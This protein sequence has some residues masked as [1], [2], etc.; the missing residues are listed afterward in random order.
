MGG[1]GAPISTAIQTHLQEELPARADSLGEF[2]LTLVTAPGGYGKTT[3]VKRWR[4]LLDA[5][6]RAMAWLALTELHADPTLFL[7]DL[8]DALRGVLPASEPDRP[9]FGESIER[10]LPQR[11]GLEASRIARLLT[12][13]LRALTDRPLLCLDAFEHLPRESVSFGI[14]DALLRSDPCPLH[15]VVTT[16]GSR[17]DAATLLLAEGEAQEV[18]AEEL[19]LRTA[20]VSAVLRDAGVEPEE[21]LVAGLLARTQGWAMAARLAARALAELPSARRLAFV[22]EIGTQRDLFQYIGSELLGRTSPEIVRLLEASAVLGVA[23]AEALTGTAGLGDGGRAVEEAL[24]AGLLSGDG[25]ALAMHDLWAEWLR[26]RL[27]GRGDGEDWKATQERAGDALCSAGHAERALAHFV[28]ALPSPRVEPRVV[29][30]LSEQGDAWVSQGH[31][32]AVERALAALPVRLRDQVP[33][34]IAL[35]GLLL[36]GSD[37]DEAI[38]HLKSAAEAYGQTGNTRAEFMCL[39]ELG[40][41][42]ANE[43]RLEETLAI[44][45]RALSLRRLVTEPT[46]RGFVVLALGAGAMLAGR[47]RLALRLTDAAATYDHH[48]RERGGIGIIQTSILFQQGAWNDAYGRIEGL[49]ARPEQRQHGLSYHALQVVRAGIDSAR[50]ADPDG[51]RARLEEATEV[52]ADAHQSLNQQRAEHALAD[53]LQRQH[54]DEAA[55]RHLERAAALARRIELWEA[56]AAALGSLARL[57]QRSGD[58]D[59]ARDAALQVLERLDR[60]EAWSTRW[61]AFFSAPGIALACCVAADLGDAQRALAFLGRHRRRLE[62][63]ELPLCQHAVLTCAARVASRAGDVAGARK[64]LRGAWQAAE[65]AGLVH[66]S[67][68]LDGELLA[69]SCTEARVQGVSGKSLA[70]CLERLGADRPPALRLRSFGGL[71]L[72]REGRRVPDRAWRGAT[73]RR[74]LM[75]LLAAEGRALTRERIEADLW[76]ELP[77]DR[78]RNNLRVAI[79]RLRD[80]LEPRRRRGN[81]VPLLDVA[82]ERV[83]LTPDAIAAWD[84]SGW[85]G[86]LE[87]IRSATDAGDEGGAIDAARAASASFEA[88]FLPESYDDWVLEL[89]RSLETQLV[90]QGLSLARAWLERGG[91]AAAVALARLVLARVPDEE[92]AWDVL[93]QA[94]TQAGDRSSAKRASEAARRQLGRLD[95]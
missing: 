35:R 49:L 85:R 94:H 45:R 52:F 41:L 28:A 8:L 87:G 62:H 10:L 59:A 43:N 64:A 75:R 31:R 92:S 60:P 63:G 14:V 3:L 65:A 84:V 77:P 55:A 37:P 18:N 76:P 12:R 5:K 20:Q 23:S 34:L 83:A 30:L 54:E 21:E 93:V 4:E 86:A 74:L 68:E 51:V 42:A 29:E 72:E 66:F 48:P 15:L 56:E 27:R 91:P 95:A 16:R 19:M 67:P 58:A 9:A 24:D 33:G 46:L 32:R 36:S 81:P 22:R 26:E 70:G 44:Q 1:P 39:H 80:A 13:E 89:R 57:L 47:Y 71:A 50:G 6:G 7:E 17:P 11:G 82:G 61:G 79:S 78:A 88:D 40:I 69:W 2:H 38:T 25:D 53:H 90:E 73:S